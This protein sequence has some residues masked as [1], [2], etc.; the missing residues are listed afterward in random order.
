[1]VLTLFAFAPLTHATDQQVTNCSN[2]IE[3]RA[4][5]T[6]MQNSGGGTLTFNCGTATIVLNGALPTITAD[7]T[8]DGGGKITISG[9]NGS[10][11]FVTDVTLTLNN[12]TISNGYVTGDD[13]GAIRGGGTLNINNCKFLNNEAVGGSGGAIV[14]YGPLNITNSE[15]ASNKGANGGALY[16]RFAN[17]VTTIT[18]SNFH[19]NQT[20]DTTNGWGGAILVW[21]GAS[22]TVSSTTLNMNHALHGGAVYVFANSWLTLNNGTA[23]T[24]NESD[25]DKGDNGGGITNNGTIALTNVTLS[26][27]HAP[28]DGGGIYSTGTATLTNVTLNDNYLNFFGGGGGIYSSG[29]LTLTNSTLS[30][31]AGWNG[32]GIYQSAGTATLT[33]V[34][35]YGNY[36]GPASG[37][38]SIHHAAGTLNVK[39]TI[40]LGS[41]DS[42]YG[43]VGGS[44]NLS[45]DG[46]CGFGP[47]RDN[48]TNLNLGPLANNGGLT[49]THLPQ[50]GSA[51]I[52]NGTTSGAPARDQRGYVRAGPAPD[53]GAVEFG[54]TL[55]HSLGNISTRALTQT[56][57]NVLIGGLIVS[58]SGPKKVILRALGPTLGQ[59]PFNVPGALQDPVLELYNSSGLI[60]SNDNWGSASNA[61]AISASG[62]A[63][64]NS[65]ESAILTDLNPGNYTAIVRGANNTTGVALVEGYDLDNAAG[66]QLGNISTRA[67]V[68]AGNN[69]MIAGVIIKGPD[70]ENVI[71]R[72][73]GPTLGQ[74]PFNVPNALQDPTLELRDSQGTLL[75]SNDNWK[76]T[77]Q[78]QIQ[79]SGYAP[80]NDLESAIFAILT[81]ANYTAILRGKNNT[82]GNALIEVYALN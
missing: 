71:V 27:N 4:D 50:S 38:G 7:T 79:A 10:R 63:P 2:D 51:A 69:V 1:M 35:L 81:P 55:P 67:F 72:G 26:G 65:K 58:G 77:Q 64:P 82:I 53:V 75:R 37:T 25:P 39:N 12:I 16:P 59:P 61:A 48:V 5:L 62:Y 78:A 23:L 30:R 40:I 18:G 70:N 60:T 46:T 52:D 66:S 43:S 74:P 73:L 20:T 33:N 9:G 45:N 8:I 76:D 49:M 11:V 28:N 17:A 32:G 15:F 57:N 31:N 13:G 36:F 21:D 44:F 14:A 42:C 29:T 19:D 80:P 6:A 24:D 68:Q 3:L 22:V 47:G 54:G 41:G 56:G 34:T